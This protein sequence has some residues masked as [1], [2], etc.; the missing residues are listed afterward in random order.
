MTSKKNSFV[1]FGKWTEIN[2]ES[3]LTYDNADDEVLALFCLFS[4]GIDLS[5][6]DRF[7]EE[8]PDKDTSTFEGLI[9]KRLQARDAIKHLPD[10]KGVE[11]IDVLGKRITTLPHVQD[12]IS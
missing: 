12:R 6:L 8:Y 10:T 7:L 1:S 4:L 3:T 9:F 5:E 11:S 2:G